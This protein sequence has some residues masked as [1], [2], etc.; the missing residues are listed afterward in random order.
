MDW[1]Q[2]PDDEGCHL[3][4][5]VKKLAYNNLMPLQNLYFWNQHSH[6][7]LYNVIGHP[8]KSDNDN[9]KS[10]RYSSQQIYFHRYTQQS[11]SLDHL[12]NNSEVDHTLV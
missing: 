11:H 10:S 4:A 2:K 7:N 5:R 9:K 12:E 8:D 3:K 6:I 1:K